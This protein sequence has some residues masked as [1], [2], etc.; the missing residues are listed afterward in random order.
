MKE[1]TSSRVMLN[2]YYGYINISDSSDDDD[3]D[4]GDM[5]IGLTVQ[6]YLLHVA[7]FLL[8]DV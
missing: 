3:D 4:D 6:R 2:V 8:F 5:I 1:S 7:L